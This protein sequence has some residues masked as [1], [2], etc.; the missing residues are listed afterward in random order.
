M[1]MHSNSCNKDQCT[2]QN[3]SQ[4]VKVFRLD[5]EGIHKTDFSVN[6]RKLVSVTRVF[7]W[8]VKQW[9]TSFVIGKPRL[10]EG[11]S[12]KEILLVQQALNLAIATATDL[13]IQYP[14]GSRGEMPNQL[15]QPNVCSACPS[16]KPNPPVPESAKPIVSRI[17]KIFGL[18]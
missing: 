4:F 3:S 7:N 1:F 16:C 2:C 5:A 9:T 14:N 11:F 17:L 8:D 12:H 6:D 15:E 10:V 13:E 18:T